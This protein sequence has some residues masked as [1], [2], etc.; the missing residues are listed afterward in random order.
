MTALYVSPVD[1]SPFFSD[2]A[3]SNGIGPVT[4]EELTF[5]VL[6]SDFDL[7][8]RLDLFGA[9]GHLEEDI[10]KVQE[11]QRYEQAPRL[12]WNCGPDF[13]DEFLVVD[14]DKTS[15]DFL[16]PMVGRGA[17]YADIDGD[18][19]IDILIF[20]CGQAPRLLRNDQA[21]GNNWLRVK[22]TG[23]GNNKEAIGALITAQLP[24]GTSQRR[25]ISP[26]CSYQSQVELIATFGLGG[27]DVV[28]ELAIRW[29]D[30]SEQVLQDTK[31]GQTLVVQQK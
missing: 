10:S 21:A 28:D 12:M 22:L 14:G 15:Q 1:E 17:S 16:K 23:K 18:G 27:L 30:G 8:G 24:D 5:G 6:F 9:N 7:D 29:P 13:N 2:E 26:T 31:V 3:V 19:D 4:R 11:S 20:G 25:M